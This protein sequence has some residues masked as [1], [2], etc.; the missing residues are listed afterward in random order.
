MSL[1]TN[2]P[3]CGTPTNTAGLCPVYGCISP[4][5]TIP[6]GFIE[7]QRCGRKQ[8]CQRDQARIAEL[9]AEIERRKSHYAEAIEHIKEVERTNEALEAERDRLL[10]ALKECRRLAS[11]AKE[12]FAED[13]LKFL[14][15][16][17]QVTD[18][19]LQEKGDE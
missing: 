15:S 3:R 9:E 8:E 10:E 7:T 18:A 13:A 14:A 4:V 16:I 2:C 6:E 5:R 1:L 17:E 11:S 12:G 19:A